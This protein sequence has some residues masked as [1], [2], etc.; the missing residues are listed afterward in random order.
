MQPET[1]V[2]WLTTVTG[3]ALWLV[4]FRN[5]R[6]DPGPALGYD[7]SVPAGWGL[8]EV[9]GIGFVW[10]AAQTLAYSAALMLAGYSP[11]QTDLEPVERAGPLLVSGVAQ[12]LV[13]G[14]AFSY[15]AIRYR[16]RLQDFGLAGGQ[17]RRGIRAGLKGF[18]MWVP[19][20]WTIQQLLVRVVEYSHP[21]L[22]GLLSAPVP[23]VVVQ[24]WLMAVVVAPVTEEFLFRV[25]VQG[26]F[27][28]IGRTGRD[29][30][31]ES[32]ILGDRHPPATA[33]AVAAHRPIVW[34]AIWA[35]SLLFAVA[36]YS[37]G[38]APISLFVLS[39]GLGY[40]YQR[41]GSV[42]ACIVMHLLLNLVT[43]ILVSIGMTSG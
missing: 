13:V 42:L 23:Q 4:W 10:I 11:E 2:F 32:L 36:H 40:L 9:L 15:L 31:G 8:L 3:A 12:L 21:A 39:L 29:T 20:V 24:T 14:L 7:R 1:A 27:Q 35:T 26:W 25:V 34:P 43:M 18:A 37:Q 19:V 17:N 30:A 16:Y 33:A 41:T 22:D 38:P 28:R 5:W 6:R